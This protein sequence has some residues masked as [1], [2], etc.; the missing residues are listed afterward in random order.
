M[1]VSSHAWLVLGVLVIGACRD[2][3]IR[4]RAE[5]SPDEQTYL[6]VDD[7]NGG[8]CGPLVVDGRAWPHK[9][10]DPGSIEAGLHRIACGDTAGYLAFEVGAGSTYHFDYWGP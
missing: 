8:H 9:I 2:Q 5:R 3:D 7:D 4:G 1:S 10:H 6:V